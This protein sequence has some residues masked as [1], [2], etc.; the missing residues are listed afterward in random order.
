MKFVDPKNDIAFKKI[1]GS[2]DTKEILMSFLNAV[3]DFKQDKTIVDVSL[4]NPYQ[5]PKIEAL[6]ETIL[7]IKATNRGGEHFIVEMQK[8]N[9]GNFAKRSLYYTSKAYVEQLNKGNDYNQLKKVYFI[10]LLSF[11]MFD[12]EDYISRHLILNQATLK[13]EI[14][15][16]EFT[17]IELSKFK[18]AL[19]DLNSNLDKWLFFIKN[20]QD[21]TLVPKVFSNNDVFKQAFAVASQY[22]WNQ[23]ELDV[24]DYMLLK[25]FDE[26]NALKT[27]EKKGEERGEKI[28]KEIGDKQ[29]SIRIAQNLLKQ[30]IAINIIVLSTGLSKAD[31][32]ALP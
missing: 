10:G 17:F 20:A 21:L 14:K 26:T 25:E 28:G 9:L 4:A 1:F 22:Q 16:F 12:N 31:I 7:D 5:V 23:Q 18:K 15:D 24:Y 27:A 11:D 2:E 29:A 19:E 3:L 30:G 32:K 6:K 13:Q 8:K